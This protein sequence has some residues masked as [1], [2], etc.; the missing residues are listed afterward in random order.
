MNPWRHLRAKWLPAEKEQR[1]DTCWASGQHWGEADMRDIAKWLL[2]A[3]GSLIVGALA[4]A[5]GR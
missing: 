2:L 1:Y 4:V 3:V 5:L